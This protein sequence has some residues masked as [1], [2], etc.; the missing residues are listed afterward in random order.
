MT[1]GSTDVKNLPQ[2]NLK[3]LT[4]TPAPIPH[5]VIT[6]SSWTDLFGCNFDKN[7]D[8]WLADEHGALDELSHAQLAAGSDDGESCAKYHILQL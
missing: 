5:T 2:L 6:S 4:K 1:V 8:L 7:G 3:V